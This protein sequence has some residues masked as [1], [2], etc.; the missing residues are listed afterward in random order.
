MQ[1]FKK[2]I[3]EEGVRAFYKGMLVILLGVGPQIAIQFGV[4]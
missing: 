4:V 2:T 1:T 3:S